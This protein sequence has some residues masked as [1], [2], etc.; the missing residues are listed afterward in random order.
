MKKTFIALF[1]ALACLTSCSINIELDSYISGGADIDGDVRNMDISWNN[2]FI[3]VRYWANNYISFYEE[4]SGTRPISEPMCYYYDGKNLRIRSSRTSSN[5][6]SKALIINVPA[7]LYLQNLDIETS[8]ADI[9]VDLD[10][11]YLD[12][13]TDYGDIVYSTENT[14][15]SRIDIENYNGETELRL[16]VGI[17]GFKCT[18][19]TAGDLISEFGPLDQSASM[20]WY[21]YRSGYTTIDFESDYMGLAIVINKGQ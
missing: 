15:M 5:S 6:G 16:P 2:G 17:N 9:D 11:N 4:A 7:G 14:S 3:K 13:E 18:M 8:S 10:C 12:I 21:I 1:A 19:D 20:G